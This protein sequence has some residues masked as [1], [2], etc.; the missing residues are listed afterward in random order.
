VTLLTLPD[1]EGLKDIEAVKAIYRSFVSGKWQ[2]RR[3][4]SKGWF[5]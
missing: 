4:K 1:G 5:K 3:I 2:D